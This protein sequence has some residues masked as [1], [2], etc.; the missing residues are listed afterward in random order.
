MR[1]CENTHPK[2]IARWYLCVTA[3]HVE[4]RPADADLVGA[5]WSRNKNTATAHVLASGGRSYDAGP[6]AHAR[7]ARLD[8]LLRVLRHLRGH[9]GARGPS[10][11]AHDACATL[12]A[13]AR[14]DGARGARG[15]RERR[16]E[17]VETASEQP[18]TEMLVD[19]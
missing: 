5:H 9:D 19:D 3:T 6:V 14:A 15:A 7:F 4:R 17:R 11:G 2:A 16:T 1:R 18:L 13:T 12:G 10:G 8:L